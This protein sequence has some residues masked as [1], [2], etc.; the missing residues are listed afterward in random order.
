MNDSYSPHQDHFSFISTN[1]LEAMEKLPNAAL[2][3]TFAY[4][5]ALLCDFSRGDYIGNAASLSASLGRR[6]R[7]GGSGGGVG[8]SVRVKR[9][10]SLSRRFS[11]TTGLTKMTGSNRSTSSSGGRQRGGGHSR[12]RHS[13]HGSNV[14]AASKALAEKKDNTPA[15]PASASMVEA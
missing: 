8:G 13:V 15:V 11:G 4:H 6:R 9:S 3:D 10:N 2:Y 12:G 14:Y 7:W 1:R 5:T